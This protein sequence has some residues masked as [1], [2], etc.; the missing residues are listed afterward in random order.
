MTLAFYILIAV[1]VGIAGGTQVLVNSNLNKSADLPL[2]TLVV[3][4]V[5]G[6]TILIIYL[7]F[8]R[9]S[10]TV[11]KNA[12][13]YAFLGGILG[14]AIVMGSTFLVPKLGLT[15]ISGIAIA[16]QLCFALAA[17][18][19]GLFGIRQIAVD[20]VRI[21]A[22]FLMIIGIYLFFK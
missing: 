4:M 16:S 10:F 9:Q 12:D 3:N 11:L 5:A 21:I 7:I 17:D 20:P 15:I 19:F 13:W 6:V 8:S 1:A 18:H 22:L 2:T 14:V